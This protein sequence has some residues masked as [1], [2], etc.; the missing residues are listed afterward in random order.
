M[1]NPLDPAG[2]LNTT[3]YEL[4]QVYAKYGTLPPADHA[5]LLALLAIADALRALTDQ[6][7]PEPQPTTP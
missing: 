1:T 3:N 6:L 4:A 7:K 5:H 2:L